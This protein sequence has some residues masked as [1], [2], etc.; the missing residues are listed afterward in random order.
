MGATTMPE[1]K[2]SLLPTPLAHGFDLNC[3]AAAAWDG[4]YAKAPDARKDA[5]AQRE[6]LAPKVAIQRSE[7]RAQV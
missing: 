5:M 7:L 6:L 3:S 2:D 4:I 1:R